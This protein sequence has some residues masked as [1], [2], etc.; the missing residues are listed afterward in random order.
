MELKLGCHCDIHLTTDTD[1]Y[2]Y[3]YEQLNSFYFMT[4]MS[5]GLGGPGFKSWPGNTLYTFILSPLIT[6]SQ[7]CKK[8][9]TQL[10]WWLES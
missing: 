6:K 7:K 2:I 3:I 5:F 10:N 9:G 8:P 1:I 4:S